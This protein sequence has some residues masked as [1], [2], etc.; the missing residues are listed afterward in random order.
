[1]NKKQTLIVFAFFFSFLV[2]ISARMLTPLPFGNNPLEFKIEKGMT[3][4]QVVEV[5]AQKKLIRDKWAFLV[6][7]RLTN[8]TNKIRAGYYPIWGNTSPWQIFEALKRGKIIEFE[9]TIVPGDSLLEIADKF[10]ALG[11]TKTDE[12]NKL[13]A[14]KDFLDTLDID[15]P[16][17]EGYLFPETYKFPKGLEAEDILSNMVYKLR[18][19]YNAEMFDRTYALKLNERDVLTMASIIEKEAVI[20]SERAVIAGVY[21]NR[22]RKKMPLQA[23]P[24]AVYGVKSS[25][26]KITKQD[27]LR[28]T[29]Y[30]TYTIS[31]LP[32]GPIASPGLKSI[33]AAL[34]PADVPY[35]YF[36]SN[37]DGTHNFSTTLDSHTDAVRAYRE[38]KKG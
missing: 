17:L 33:I 31:G 12:F 18:E 4:R 8:I 22:L 26:D 37:N 20:D 1:M 35:L 14:D 23:D 36:V 9:L 24:T 2:Y 11:I 16:S 29:R 27:L 3:Y 6:L 30:N 25:R 5:L 21:Y 7:G 13:S 10:S 32:P 28:K 34:Y 15:A 38:K 19:K